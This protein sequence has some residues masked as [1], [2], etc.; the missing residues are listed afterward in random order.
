MR[1]HAA[2]MEDIDL[3]MFCNRWYNARRLIPRKGYWVSSEFH[4]L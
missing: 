4:F 3:Q 2:K 1:D